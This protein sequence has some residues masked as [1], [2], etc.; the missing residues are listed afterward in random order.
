M[1]VGNCLEIFLFIKKKYLL[2]VTQEE[3]IGHQAGNLDVEIYKANKF[4]RAH[5]IKTTF[6]F[7]T[8]LE[9][10]SNKYLRKLSYKAITDNGHKFIV[11]NQK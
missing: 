7:V 8:N 9:V 2:V 5:K 3:R 4:R 6:I 1:V 11:I 10:V